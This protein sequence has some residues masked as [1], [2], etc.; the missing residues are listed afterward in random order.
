MPAAL[1][2]A[3]VVVNDLDRSIGFYRDALSYSVVFRDDD[4]GELIASMIG[5]PG[6][7]CALA[8]LASPAGGPRIELIAFP[9]ALAGPVGGWGERRMAAGQGH[10]GF[11]VDDLDAAQAVVERHGAVLVGAL[12]TFPDGRSAYWREPGGSTV[13]LSEPPADAHTP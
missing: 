12:T 13:E 1:G 8:Q 4:L 6:S 5:Q 7:T 3:S 10:L 11:E 2:H 9:R